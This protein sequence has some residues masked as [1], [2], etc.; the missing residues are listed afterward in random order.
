MSW[1][2][3]LKDKMSKRKYRHRDVAI[4]D[5]LSAL[6]Q[7]P[8]LKPEV[9]KFMYN[10][11]RQTELVCFKGTIPVR[12]KGCIYNIPVC[13]WLLESHPFIPPLIYVTP[14]STM[15]IKPGKHVDN[16]GRVYLPYLTDWKSPGSDLHG[17][18]QVLCLLFGDD[19]PVYSR[20]SQPPNRPPQPQ[21]RYGSQQ[22]YYGNGP[23]QQ[24][25]Q[26]QQM[27][28]PASSSMGMPMP[29]SQPSGYPPSSM[30]YPSGGARP[31]PYPTSTS[32]MPPYPTVSAVPSTGYQ[33]PTSYASAN[34][35]P[36]YPPKTTGYPPYSTANYPSAAQPPVSSQQQESSQFQARSGPVR[37]QTILDPNILKASIL[38]SVEDKL[39]RRVREVFE[40]TKHELDD[41]QSTNDE[42]KARSL[43]LE[44]IL[45]SLKQ[46][47]TMSKNNMELLDRKNKELS[48]VISKLENDAANMK[49]DEAVVT[50]APLYKQILNTF[51]EESAVE[52]AIYYLGEALRREVI[53]LESFLK[54]VRSLSRKQFLLRAQLKKARQ[55]AGLKELSTN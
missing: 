50:T 2:S 54:A 16:T 4:P 45:D 13:I 40:Q 26:Q 33:P 5:A 12:Y 14:T 29:S 41:L 46:D 31:A 28:Y 25:Q 49:I 39:R 20:G 51:A 3:W 7:F 9:D 1:E 24:Q 21:P 10:D 42:L 32:S 35:V 27:P 18:I 19:P 43:K 37:Q 17:L 38:S 53:D 22:P 48:E 30:P 36:Q 8:D 11:G 52:D 6:R 34:Q 47:E 55:T 15:I 44:Q 23:P